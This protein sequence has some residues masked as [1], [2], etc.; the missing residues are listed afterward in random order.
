MRRT[1]RRTRMRSS[2]VEWGAGKKM[3]MEAEASA[4]PTHGTGANRRG[5]P[6]RLDAEL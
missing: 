5:Q 2:V 4:I 3:V 6:N 1:R